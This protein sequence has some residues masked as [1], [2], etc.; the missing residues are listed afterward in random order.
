M[1]LIMGN[2]AARNEIR[3][4]C[5]AVGSRGSRCFLNIV[6]IQER[7]RSYR[8]RWCIDRRARYIDRLLFSDNMQ[9][10]MNYWLRIRIDNNFLRGLD[11]AWARHGNGVV[12]ERYGI[13]HELTV[14]IGLCRFCPVRRLGFQH[15]HHALDGTVLRVVNNTSN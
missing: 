7:D 12:T 9:L 10:E 3:N 14:C 1:E 5:E 6:S 11:E 4:H 13:K 15:Y 2:V 8:I